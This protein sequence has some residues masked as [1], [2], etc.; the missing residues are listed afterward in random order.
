MIGTLYRSNGEHFVSNV[1]YKLYGDSPTNLWGELRP[2]EYG[3][4]DDGEAYVIEL[5]DKRKC[6]CSLKKKVNAAVGLLPGCFV[7]NFR[8]TV[9]S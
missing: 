6:Q 9:T 7:Y 8:G 1:D 3:R 2:A 5:E 4:I